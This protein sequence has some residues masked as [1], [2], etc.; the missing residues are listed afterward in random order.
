MQI[1]LFWPLSFLPTVPSSPWEERRLSNWTGTISAWGSVPPSPTP[2][3]LTNHPP[4]P[5][6]SVTPKLP[7][8]NKLTQKQ[9]TK[10]KQAPG[11]SGFLFSVGAGP[12]NYRLQKL[13]DKRLYCASHFNKT[14]EPSF[15]QKLSTFAGSPLKNTHCSKQT[16]SLKNISHFLQI[17]TVKPLTFETFKGLQNAK[18]TTQTISLPSNHKTLERP[19]SWTGESWGAFLCLSTKLSFLLGRMRKS[20]RISVSQSMMGKTLC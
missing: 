18:V 12:Q 3:R 10:V 4:P 14:A 9:N 20:H 8:H 11:V 13:D 5:L 16:V 17:P 6:R 2:S 1:S 7:A 19:E 15:F